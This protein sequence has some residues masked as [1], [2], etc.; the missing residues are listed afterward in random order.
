[1][2]SSQ[3]RTVCPQCYAVLEIGRPADSVAITCGACDAAFESTAADRTSQRLLN[4]AAPHLSVMRSLDVDTSLDSLFVSAIVCL[5]KHWLLLL[6]TSIVVNLVWFATIGFPIDA[7]VGGWRQLT[8]GTADS[9]AITATLGGTV[10]ISILATP[11]SAYCMIVLVRLML[12]ITRH[13]ESP[14]VRG[15]L[16]NVMASLRVPFWSVLRLSALF[17]IVGISMGTLFGI[18]IIAIV[19]LSF[20][21]DPQTAIWV[22]TL[23]VGAVLIAAVFVLQW[24]LWPAVFF[25]SD[26]RA[27]L[28]TSL[29]W[30]ARL[31]MRHR[32]LTLSLVTVYFVLAT[33]GSLLFY[34]GQIIT[35]PLAMLPLAIGYL[36]MT[37]GE[38]EP[39]ARSKTP[40]TPG[41]K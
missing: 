25:I 4:Q 11:V 22:G 17:L 34:V 7:L 27:D 40:A 20:T 41:P 6:M 29:S 9:G 39:P 38:T 28:M 8:S 31:A 12:A 18:G 5:R 35:T 13:G 19:G 30:G 16:A 2:I 21:M 23:S 10:L 14:Q 15:V 24:L 33:A 37:G 1:M 26:G 32:K 3:S 36:R